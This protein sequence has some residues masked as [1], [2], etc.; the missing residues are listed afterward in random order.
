M[1]AEAIPGTVLS[2]ERK[3]RRSAGCGPQ[4]EIVG[5]EEE[6]SAVGQ[7]GAESAGE[8]GELWEVIEWGGM[9]YVLLC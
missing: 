9:G 2:A 6:E 7:Q 1:S 3:D 4:A 5:G 8:D